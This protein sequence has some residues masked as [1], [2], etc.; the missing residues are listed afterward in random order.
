MTKNEIKTEQDAIDWVL[1]KIP[2]AVKPAKKSK[3]ELVYPY[4]SGNAH[5]IIVKELGKELFKLLN[6]DNKL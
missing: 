1:F 5:D 4:T 3:N 6:D 2:L